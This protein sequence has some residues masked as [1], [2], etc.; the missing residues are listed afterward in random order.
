VKTV[1]R[2]S[3]PSIQCSELLARRTLA[4]LFRERHFAERTRHDPAD[5]HR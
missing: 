5:D 2:E 4:M 1:G 3:A